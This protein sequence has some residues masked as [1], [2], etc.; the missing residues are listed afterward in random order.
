M[1]HEEVINVGG[2]QRRLV[3]TNGI[4]SHTYHDYTGTDRHAGVTGGG[5]NVLCQEA[6]SKRG[7]PEPSVHGAASQPL[8]GRLQG[9]RPGAC[10]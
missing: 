1:Y 5:C 7:L 3:V 2:E 4:P 10:G 6:E 9:E 8:S